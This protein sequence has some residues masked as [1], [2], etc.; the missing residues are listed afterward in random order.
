MQALR[1]RKQKVSS[2][3]LDLSMLERYWG[4]ERFY[5][6]TAPISMI[7]ALYEALRLIMEEGLEARF[8]RH[9]LNHQA[10]AAGLEILGIEFLVDEPYRL[11][12]LNAVK[13]PDGITDVNVRKHLLHKFGIELGGGLGSLKGKIWRIGLMGHSSTKHNVILLLTALESAL[14]HEGMTLSPGASV[15]AAMEIYSKHES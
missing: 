10:L 14:A 5:H 3:Y 15:A 8:T 4:D 9:R 12:M 6:H 11:P 2:W 1:S 7:Y 13:I